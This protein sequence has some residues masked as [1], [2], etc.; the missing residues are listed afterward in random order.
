MN[1]ALL[2][3]LTVEQLRQEAARYRLPSTG[4]KIELI[5]TIISHLESDR[6]VS[7]LL[8]SIPD[9]EDAGEEAGPSRQADSPEQ[10]DVL[11]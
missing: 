10:T 11:R 6:P 9:Q 8:G 1:R 2:E 7:D 3:R 5:E 4:R